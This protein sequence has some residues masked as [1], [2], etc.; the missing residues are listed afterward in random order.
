MQRTITVQ[1][2]ND[3]KKTGKMIKSFAC[4]KAK[5]LPYARYYISVREMDEIDL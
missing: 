5:A 1:S 3:Y 4:L 2:L